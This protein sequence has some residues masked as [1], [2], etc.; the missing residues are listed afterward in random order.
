M[1]YAFLSCQLGYCIGAVI[2]TAFIDYFQAPKIT[3]INV[4]ATTI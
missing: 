4:N 1:S 3:P 2:L